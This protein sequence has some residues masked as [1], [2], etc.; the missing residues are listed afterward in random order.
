VRWFP[1]LPLAYAGGLA[2]LYRGNYEYIRA[3]VIGARV[4]DREGALPVVGRLQ[5]WLPFQHHELAAEVIALRASG[6]VVDQDVVNA[7]SSGR[8]GKRFT[9]VSDHLHSRLRPRLQRLIP[10]DS[11]FDETFDRFEILIAVL[12]VDQRTQASPNADEAWTGPWIPD[13]FSGRVTWRDRYARGDRR[14]ERQMY[15]ELKRRQNSWEPL[16]AGLFDGSV[17][18]ALAAFEEYLPSIEHDRNRH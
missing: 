16:I 1:L 3:T 7:L 4:R 6:E 17:E 13:G 8:R 15:L 14:L 12:M 11:A 5:P 10:D 2:A 18:R 9:P